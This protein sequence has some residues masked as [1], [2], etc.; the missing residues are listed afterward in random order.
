LAGSIAVEL[1]HVYKYFGE[2]A[3]V[4]DVSRHIANGD[5][6][7]LGASG[8]GKTTTLRMIAGFEL[9]S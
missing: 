6:S 7:L 5:F 2:T 3:A 8:C 4:D 1:R 9:P